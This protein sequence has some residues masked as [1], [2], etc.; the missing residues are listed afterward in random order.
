MGASRSATV[1]M[2]YLMKELKNRKESPV[3]HK[4][5]I[6]F[7][8]EKRPIVNPTF[9]FTKDLGKSFIKSNDQ[10]EKNKDDK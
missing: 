1:L 4:D 9:R 7:L 6:N 5:V 10:D 2:Y 8:R 3:N